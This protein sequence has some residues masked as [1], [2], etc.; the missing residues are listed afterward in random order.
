M[1]AR[2]RATAASRAD[3][4]KISDSNKVDL[5]SALAYSKSDYFQQV[6]GQVGLTKMI[7]YARQLGLAEKTGI[8]TSNE[9]K[10]EEFG[11]G[12]NR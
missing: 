7:S 5:T 2:W 9:S 8:N 1:A 3:T 11:G 6:G 10:P 12:A 4:A